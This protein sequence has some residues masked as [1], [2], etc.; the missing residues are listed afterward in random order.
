MEGLNLKITKQDTHFKKGI[1]ANGRFDAAEKQKLAKASK[2]FE[3]MLT[4][5]MIKSMTKTTD[6]LLGKDNYGGDVLDV[7]FET[8]ISKHITENQGMGVAEQIYKSLTGEVLATNKTFSKEKLLTP[9]ISN[10]KNSE[11]KV[12]P[13][14]KIKPNS[15]ALKRI[16]DY[17]DLIKSASKKFN[18]DEQLIKSVILT[19]SAGKADAKSKANAKGLMQLMDSTASDMGVNNPWNPKENINGGTKYLSKL[20]N[21]FDGDTDLALAAYNAGPGNVKKYDGIPPFKETQNYIKRVNNY[22]NT[23]E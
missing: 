4:S 1:E 19:E 13:N 6:G 23:L 21:D 3:S 16:E 7:L 9:I 10:N 20:L 14:N 22:L 11:L 5:M 18:V 8:E 15:N 17:D 2:E 12:I